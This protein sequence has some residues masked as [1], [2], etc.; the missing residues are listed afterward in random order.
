MSSDETDD[1]LERLVREALTARATGAVGDDRSAPPLAL[2]DTESRGRL[3]GRA[4]FLAPL[5]A[6]AAVLLAVGLVFALRGPATVHGRVVGAGTGAPGPAR[7]S[8]KPSASPTKPAATPVHVSLKWSDGSQFGVGI[9]VIAYFS[10]KV[11]D[12]RAFAAAATVTVNGAPANGAWYFEYSDPATG[13]AME[14]HYRLQDYW[15]AHA[16]IRVELP[17]AGK[18][19]GTGLAFD[20]NLTLDFSTGAAHIATVSDASHTLTLTSD[21]TVVG[22]YPVSLGAPNTRTRSG[23]KVIMEKGLSICMSGPG[24][25]ECGVKDTQRLTYDGEYLH[26]AP[27]NVYNITHGIDSSNGCTNLLPADAVALYKILEIGDVVRYPDA[28]GGRMQLGTG[29]GDWNVPWTQW[30]TGGPVPTH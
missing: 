20:D 18:S 3:R 22:T 6:A 27:W 8:G 26:A 11:T 9:P 16:R 12:G 13:H 25:S 14:A 24:Y 17:V 30:L 4:R 19:A 2:T 1:R 10:R 15:P 5:A 28:N 29:Y 7:S 23:T 21:G